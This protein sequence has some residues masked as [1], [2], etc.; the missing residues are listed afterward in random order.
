MSGSFLVSPGVAVKEQDLTDIVPSIATSP[1]ATAGYFEWGPVLSPQLVTKETELVQTFGKPNNNTYNSFFTAANF[2]AYANNLLVTRAA[3][4]WA[5]NAGVFTAD[6]TVTIGVNQI[7]VSAGSKTVTGTISASW[8]NSYLI[9]ITGAIVGVVAAYNA[10]SGSNPESLTL[11]EYSKVTYT[12]TEVQPVKRVSIFNEDQYLT[13]SVD[14]S[15]VG[16]FVAKYPGSI[17][18]SLSVYIADS[19]TFFNKYVATN[20]KSTHNVSI[21]S[22]VRT[23]NVVV[24]TTKTPHNLSNGQ[25]VIIK[26]A[27]T[28]SGTYAAISS[29]TDLTFTLS[30]IGSNE[31]VYTGVISSDQ[32]YGTG[33][34]FS[35]NLNIGSMILDG[36][37]NLI[38]TVANVDSVSKITL[39]AEA[40][41]HYSDTTYY[42]KWKYKDLFQFTP[43]TSAYASNVNS[44]ND[45]LHIVVV[46]SDGMFS[47][48]AGTVLETYQSVSKASNALKPDGTSN[49]Y[50]TVLQKNSKYVYAANM[51]SSVT[52]WYAAATTGLTFNTLSI[53][54]T[55]NDLNYGSNGIPSTDGDLMTAFD[56]YSNA[57]VYDVALMPVGKASTLLANFVIGLAETKK[58]AVAF[59]SPEDTDGSII[60]G[61]TTTQQ[62]AIINYANSITSS[63]YGIIDS[64]YKYQYDR[65]NDIYRYVPLNGDIA[66]LCARSDYTHDAWWSPAGY[67]R[68]QIKNVAKLAFNPSQYNRD[69]LFQARVNPVVSF[70]GQGTVLFGDKTAI[71]SSS[72]FDAIGIRRLFIILEK[73][74]ATAAKFKLFEFN[75]AFTR[76]QFKAMVEPFLRDVQGRRGITDFQVICDETNNNENSIMDRGLNIDI[77]MPDKVSYMFSA[78]KEENQSPA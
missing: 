39:T 37:Q 26:S 45:E 32:V 57:E 31:T 8:V 40:N 58:D 71:A 61:K 3:A 18:S 53:I 52:N 13:N 33:A 1:A 20:I 62:N 43:G 29:A 70:P 54:N 42:I 6:P 5:F 63:S 67:S 4:Q 10:A 77:Y 35:S 17:G 56:I 34:V 76:N 16:T 7:N 47:G 59:V 11:L 2:L 64:G 30:Q 46:D 66:G 14:L 68:G 48:V 41:I 38:G 50:K 21:S 28:F 55:Q 78:P 24:V 25:R 9:T 12:N 60:I 44:S 65:Y 23:N 72:A 51:P 27:G 15:Q 49:F 74:I 75:D 19:G 73:S 69:Y 22:L 36:N